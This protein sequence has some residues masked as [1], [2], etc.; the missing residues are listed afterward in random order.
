LFSLDP[1]LSAP[2]AVTGNPGVDRLLSQLTLSEK[3]SLIHGAM[4]PTSTYQ[5]Q[6]GYWVGIPHLGIPPLRFADGPPG[7]LTRVP[8]IAP[9]STMGIAAS[10]SREDA[11]LTGQ[12]LGR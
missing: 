5:G 10:F 2:P 6:A 3:I 4:E 8:S 7:I 11:R 12:V 9:T 1:Q